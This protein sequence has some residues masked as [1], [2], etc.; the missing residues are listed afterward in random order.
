MISKIDKVHTLVA[1]HGG[2]LSLYQGISGLSE[3]IK[4]GAKQQPCPK[5]GNGQT[6]F[7]FYR[8]VND[9]GGAFHNDVGAMPDGIE[10]LSWYEGKTKSEILNYILSRLGCSSQD[11]KK[12]DVYQY[13]VQQVNNHFEK[14]KD[15]NQRKQKIITRIR[16]GCTSIINTKAEIYLRSRGIKGDLTCLTN[17]LYHPALNYKEDDQSSWKKYPGIVS[18][19]SNADDDFITLHRTFLSKDGRA[20][21]EVTRQKMMLSQPG[22]LTGGHIKLDMPVDIGYGKL[23]G[24]SEGIETALSV[25]EASGCPM[26]V[27]ISDW[28]MA[29]VKLPKDIKVLIVWADVEPSGAGLR[30]AELLRSIWEPKGVEVI[31]QIPDQ[32][33]CDKLDWNDVY[34]KFGSRG[35]DFKVQLKHRVHTGVNI[36]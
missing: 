26:W 10:L 21:A 25:R 7:R 1:Q 28:I 34:Q 2:W 31:V 32:F 9:T 14:S 15:E 36:I 6:K 19:V 33:G 30:A 8:D 29:D 5:T 13:K 12:R 3:A 22:S 35:F 16:S 20:K 17:L 4:K 24:I 11:I 18:C 23:I 27:G